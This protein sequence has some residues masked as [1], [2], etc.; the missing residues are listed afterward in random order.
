MLRRPLLVLVLAASAAGC[1]GLAA[2]DGGGAAPPLNAT[3][4]S[5]VHGQVD[6]A[7]AE[8]SYKTAWNQEVAAGADRDRLEAI[9]LAALDAKSSHAD[10]MFKELRK[11]HGALGVAARARIERLVAQ[12]RQEGAWLHALELEIVTAD[13]PPA[14]SRAWEVYRAA[15]S[16]GA[17]ALL[18][19][20]QEAKTSATKEA[21]D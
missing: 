8:Q 6:K 5:A 7:L 1:T 12:A 4:Q 17:A 14:F 18:E 15:P 13:D 10:G 2:L 21:S 3:E 11:K 16:E 20:L 19:S 9:A